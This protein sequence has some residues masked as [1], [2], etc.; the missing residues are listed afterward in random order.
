MSGARNAMRSSSDIVHTSIP[1]RNDPPVDDKVASCSVI[2]LPTLLVVL[3]LLFV[4]LFLSV[5]LFA[6]EF[7]LPKLVG[8]VFVEIGEDEGE[9]FMIPGYG[10]AF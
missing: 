1:P 4:F 6:F 7:L 5:A 3:F 2:V 10:A 9:D 8:D